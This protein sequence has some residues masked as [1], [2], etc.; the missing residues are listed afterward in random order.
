MNTILAL[1]PSQVKSIYKNYFGTKNRERL[2]MILEPF[3]A[4]I[5]LCLLGHCPV[6]T[7]LRIQNNLLT[8]HF[9]VIYQGISR[10]YNDD[11]KDDLYYLF[12][13]I[14]RFNLWFKNDNEKLSKEEYELLASNAS[15]G[16][17][18]LVKTYENSENSPII[19][20]IQMYK[21]L[22]NSSQINMDEDNDMNDDK[23]NKDMNSNIDSIFK[24]IINIYNK[25]LKEIIFNLIRLCEKEKNSDI[26]IKYINGLN[27]ILN[28]THLQIKKWINDKLII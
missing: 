10:W 28:D 6:G 26:K 5:Q 13:V 14:R 18:N 22:L 25:E 4:I 3:Q 16:L 15:L 2:D 7:K 19:Y 17:S 9:P 12:H 24:N 8:L 23:I 1:P 21:T 27:E 11:K 20:V